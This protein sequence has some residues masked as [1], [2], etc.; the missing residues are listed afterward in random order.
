M[1]D[2][3]SEKLGQEV[4][5]R[6]T[7]AYTLIAV[8][9]LP[10]FGVF[11]LGWKAF[12]V[13]FLYWMENVILGGINLLKI[14]TC[15]P[16]PKLL[17]ESIQEKI[18]SLT[19]RGADI[20]GEQ[21]EEQEKFLASLQNGTGMLQASKLFFAP[22]FT[23]HYGGFCFVHGIFVCAILGSGGPLQGGFASPFDIANLA[24]G[25]TSLMLGALAL[26]ASHL[27]SYFTNFIGR[28][29][30][31]RSAPMLLMMEPYGRVIVLH[32]A[33]VFSGFFAVV[34]GS[35]IWL[36]I[37]LVC[38]KTFLDLQLHLREHK[39]KDESKSPLDLG[40]MTTTSELSD[41]SIATDE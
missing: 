10:L 41:S 6:G 4:S 9:L 21:R 22:F 5:K 16:D 13:V 26:G 1:H 17:A 7:S 33:I 3:F 36:L 25:N 8:N 15:M 28:G 30:Y 20:T 12:D 37:L 38:G 18:R 27:V 39:Q 24:F 40:A 31:R 32:I 11:F 29:E 23:V 35:P 34:L 19:D 14:L 2:I